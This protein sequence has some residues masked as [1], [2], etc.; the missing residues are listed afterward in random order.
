M[1]KSDDACYIEKVFV[2]EAFDK[3]ASTYDRGR[4]I[5]YELI[6]LLFS[7]KTVTPFSYILDL[8]CG[9]GKNTVEMARYG[10]VIGVDFSYNMVK[11]FKRRARRRGYYGRCHPVTASILHLPFREKI[12]DI[13]T[14]LAV[15]HHIPYQ[16]HREKAL[17][18]IKRIC[19]MKCVVLMTAWDLF[20]P[21][22][23]IKVLRYWIEKRGMFGDAFIEWRKRDRTIYRYYHFFRRKELKTLVEKHGFKIVKMFKWSPKRRFLKENIVV[24]AENIPT[25][26]YHIKDYRP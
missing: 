1:K 11:I 7:L 8:G 13:V 2:K 19:K 16:E 17:Q 24:I 25:S 22:N 5:W 18:E 12:S 20:Y 6:H 4:R 26:E 21:R 14:L 15:I 9:T 3:I 23:F 10:E